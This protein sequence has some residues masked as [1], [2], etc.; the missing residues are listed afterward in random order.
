MATFGALPYFLTVLLQTVHGFSALQSGLAFLVPSV[1]IALGTQLGERMAT[2]LG[3]RTTLF[4]GFGIGVVGTAV[5]AIGFDVNSTYLAV[6]P[7]LVVSGIGQGITWTGM[8]IA[9]A[10]G[11]AAKEQGV[12]SGMVSTTLN[13]GNAVG[14]AILIAIANAGLGDVEGD[15][16][17]SATA[18]GG[19]IVVLVTAAGML[20]GL[21]ITFALPR[22]TRPA[23]P[24]DVEPSPASVV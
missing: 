20:A 8:W 11:V 13:L 9:G 19:F 17:R 1:A 21:L 24:A 14:L 3:T 22:A 16:L 7:G 23:A 18:D 10:A 15:A 12:A 2:R 5:L 6:V 4:A